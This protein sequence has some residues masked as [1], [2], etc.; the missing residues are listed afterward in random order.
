MDLHENMDQIEKALGKNYH[1]S[2]KIYYNRY[3]NVLDNFDKQ[4]VE[5]FTYAPS[6]PIIKPINNDAYHTLEGDLENVIFDITDYFVDL[7]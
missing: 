4:R 7:V 2:N 3:K 5:K 6:N 1:W